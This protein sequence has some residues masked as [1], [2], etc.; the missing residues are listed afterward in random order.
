MNDKLNTLS[1]VNA[2]KDYLISLRR[3]FHRNPESSLKE[4][5]TASVI[6]NELSKFNIPSKRIGETGVLGVIHGEKV[7]ESKK[8]I[9]L[10]ADIDALIMS[11]EKNVEYKSQNSCMHAC[12][13]DV[14]TAA[15]LGAAKILKANSDLFSG[16]IRLMFQQAEEIGYGARVFIENGCLDGVERTFGFHVTSDYNVGTVCVT[17]GENNAS[18][19]YFKI[20]IRGRSA[21]ITSP[22]KAIDSLKASAKT[23]VQLNMLAE[24]AL[25]NQNVLIGIGKMVSGTAYNIISDYTEIEGTVRAFSHEGRKNIKEEITK[26]V[27]DTAISYGATPEIEW[28]DFT[29]PL[30]N[31]PKASGEVQKIVANL[32]GVDKLVTNRKPSLVGDDFAELILK[33]PGAYAYVGTRNE[34][35]PD[36]HEPQHSTTFDVDENSLLVGAALHVEYAIRFLNG[37]I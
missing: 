12:G 11:D 18:V 34:T 16:E 25:K 1:Y 30:V 4:F 14:H 37:E 13:H 8:T 36:T 26:L 15:L 19:D 9:L 6:E 35:N 20:K 33:A 27:H 7:G 29:S 3:D 23:V 32:F 28:K 22:E 5:R 10:R 31:D 2:E 21:H 24:K 17:E